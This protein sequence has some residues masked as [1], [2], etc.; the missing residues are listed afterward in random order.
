M[1]GMWESSIQ[2]NFLQRG[3]DKTAREGV[4]GRERDRRT[5]EM[6]KMETD[7]RQRQGEQDSVW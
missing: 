4:G 7:F 3:I 6:E 2:Y 5:G 1:I